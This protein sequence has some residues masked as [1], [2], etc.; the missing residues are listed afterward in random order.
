MISSMPGWLGPAEGDAAIDDDPL[1]RLLRPKAV[2]GHVHADFA[3]AAKGHKHQ[4]IGTSSCGGPQDER[5][6][7]R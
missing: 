5:R 7:R 1:A 2:G 3:D 6:R 4:F